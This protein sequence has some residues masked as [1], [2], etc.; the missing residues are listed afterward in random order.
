[1]SQVIA[2]I[3]VRNEAS[4]IATI[5]RTARA[6]LPVI[7]V[8]DASTD[9]SAVQ[10]RRAGARVLTLKQHRGKGQALRYGMAEAL[11]CGA[12][13][14][15]TLDGDGQHDPHDI[16]RFLDAAQCWPG[17]VI[18]GSRRES[19]EVMPRAR[20]Y[21]MQV[22]NFWIS[23][24]GQ[25]QVHDSQSGFRLYPIQLFSTLPLK[26]GGFLFESE[27]LM[28]AGQAGWPLYELP[29][30][31]LYPPAWHSQYRPMHDG[32]VLTAYL[33][34]RG[35]RA[36]PAQGWRACCGW[37]LREKAARQCLWQRTRRAALATVGLP[38]LG[39]CALAYLCLGRLGATWLAWTIQHLY[40]PRLLAPAPTDPRGLHDHYRRKRWKLV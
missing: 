1:M 28:K 16:P 2:V 29:I 25:C 27:V 23:W 33:L 5:V 20:F 8:D 37:R 14:V 12:T 15:V 35:L 6:Y 36:W 32:L 7:V 21:A 19:T 4:T 26:H 10:A 22:A 3:P 38:W 40:D 13:S 9:D 11:R 30:Q 34:Y 17:S 24:L 31:A 39:L 18:I